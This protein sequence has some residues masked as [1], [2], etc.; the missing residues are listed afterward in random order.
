[1]NLLSPVQIW[2]CTDMYYF[3]YSKPYL[4]L[5]LSLKFFTFKVV[6]DHQDLFRE[7]QEEHQSQLQ[8]C[9]EEPLSRFS[10]GKTCTLLCIS[11]PTL[12]PAAQIRLD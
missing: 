7:R 9:V 10:P 12:Q 1:M 5:H 8:S 4:L 2:I 3:I 11:L 6:C